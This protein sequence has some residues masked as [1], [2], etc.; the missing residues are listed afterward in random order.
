MSSNTF[1]NNSLYEDGSALAIVL[2]WGVNEDFQLG[3]DSKENV[4]T[5][6]V[7]EALLGKCLR[8]RTLGKA[9]LVAGSR[10]TLA[11]TSDG[12]VFSWGWNDRATL[13]QGHRQLE[14]KPRRVAALREYKIEQVALGGWH[15][16]AVDDKGQIFSWG[17]NEY[18][19]C[20]L[21]SDLR[22]VQTPQPILSHLQV[23]QVA[24]GGMSS[25]ALTVDGQ[26]WMW[27]EPWG[28]FSLSVDRSPRRI[29][30]NHQF[31]RIVSGAFH[32]L[33]VDRHG[34]V[35]SWGIND[36]GQLG[37]GTTNYA[38]EPEKVVDL[39][40]VCIVDIA[41]GG[42]HSVAIT[43]SGEVYVWGR[44]EYGRLGLG[45]K[46]GSSK[47]RPQKLKGL[48]GHRVI[49]ASCGGTHSM[50]VTDEGKVF[51]WVRESAICVRRFFFFP[52]Y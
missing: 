1:G 41:A 50:V 23:E 32:H 36:F 15:C 22:D 24:C 25:L 51:T 4:F 19:Q 52:E 42:W 38:T 27:G 44:G 47:L 2:G 10:N 37:I 45:D 12:D 20:A 14:K 34:R 35:F 26:L 9:P 21:P 3:L 30:N 17:G 33:A 48:E 31:V 43:D 40:D 46:S 28:D 18:G 5:P 16:L 29:D 7:V 13:G 11:V 49:E 6:K 39:D 8:R